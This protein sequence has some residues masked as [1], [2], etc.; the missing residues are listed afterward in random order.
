MMVHRG[1]RSSQSEQL[2]AG[3]GI[4]HWTNGGSAVELPPPWRRAAERAVRPAPAATGKAA[5]A[6]SPAPAKVERAVRPAPTSKTASAVSPAPVLRPAPSW[7]EKVVLRARQELKR[8]GPVPEKD[9]ASFSA[10]PTASGYDNGSASSRTGTGRH[11]GKDG[12]R[13]GGVCRSAEEEQRVA[14]DSAG[15][16]QRSGPPIVL[17]KRRRQDS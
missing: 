13:D 2:R 14:Q 4:G 8:L 12:G 11:D 16:H 1:N 6:V 5:S 17:R 7:C 10:A 3:R 15:G 9:G